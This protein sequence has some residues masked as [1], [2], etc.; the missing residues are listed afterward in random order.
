[1]NI[2]VFLI[3]LYIFINAISYAIYEIKND[4]KFGGFVIISLNIFMIIFVN[5]CTFR[6]N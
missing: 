1:M 4:N 3:S 5:F 6:F 2:T